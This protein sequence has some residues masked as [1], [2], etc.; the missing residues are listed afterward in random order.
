MKKQAIFTETAPAAV[1]PYS[2]AV[3]AGGWI[4]LS[5]QIPVDPKTNQVVRG[6]IQEQTQL[7]LRNSQRVLETAG[8]SLQNVV[9]VSLFMANMKDF[10]EINTVYSS[11]FP[12]EPLARSAVQVAR[13][14]KDVGIE[15]DMVAYTG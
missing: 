6:T 15:V 14:P 4:Y 10:S 12:S 9:K 3:K 5:G 8:A 2:Q 1:G 7:V 11:F 13:L